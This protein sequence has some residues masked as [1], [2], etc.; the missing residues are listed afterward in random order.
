MNCAS[1]NIDPAAILQAWM[2]FKELVGVTSIKSEEDYARVA[3]LVDVLLDTIRDDAAH[4]LSDVLYYLTVQMETYEAAQ[5][6]IPEVE[7]RAVLHFLME[8]HGLKQSDLADCAPQSH[9][10]AI[11]A[12]KRGISKEAAKK[13]AKRFNVATDVFL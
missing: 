2:P 7:P 9:I 13:F 10:S 8:Q 12:G 5:V 3:S 1:Q 6:A 4:P 11:L